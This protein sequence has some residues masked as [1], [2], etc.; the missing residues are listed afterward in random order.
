[1]SVPTFA[2][3]VVFSIID[4]SALTSGSLTLQSVP[5]SSFSHI[6]QMN[7]DADSTK[8]LLRNELTL[9]PAAEATQVGKPRFKRVALAILDPNLPYVEGEENTTWRTEVAEL[10]MDG[11]SKKN[12]YRLLQRSRIVERKRNSSN[13]RSIEKKN[14]KKNVFVLLGKNL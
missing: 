2:V 5:P 9:E 11:L 1:V 3:V 7:Q 8:N 10:V 14:M 6:F 4:S 13:L 12:L